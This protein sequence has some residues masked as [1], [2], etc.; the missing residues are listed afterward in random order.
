MKAHSHVGDETTR[1][2]GLV[3]ADDREVIRTAIRKTLQEDLSID[4]V[5]EALNFA[6]TIQ[7]LAYLFRC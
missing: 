2:S 1:L 3:Q 5:G 7:K 4:I 6:E